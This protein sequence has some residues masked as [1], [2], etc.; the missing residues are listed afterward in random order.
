MIQLQSEHLRLWVS[1]ADGAAITSMDWRGR[2]GWQPV[3][4]PD[5]AGTGALA[6]GLYWMLPF[7]NR[8][9]DNRLHSYI[10][11]PNNA[12]P[13]ALHGTGWERAWTVR[14][15]TATTL[16]L[17]V[18]VPADSYPFG[19][20]A[21]IDLQLSTFE[22]QA[23]LSM[24]NSGAGPIPAGLGAHPYFPKYP[25]TRLQFRARHFWLE[26]PGHL[27][28][29]AVSLPPDRDFSDSAALPASWCNN[30][31]SGW[32]HI[33]SIDQ[34]DLGYNLTLRA[35]TT[36]PELMLYSDPAL[37]RF[38]VEPQSHTSGATGQA[39]AEPAIGLA[40]LAPGATLS[41]DFVLTVVPPPDDCR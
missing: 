28:T 12:D 33:F 8:A 9:R 25:G 16:S 6:A 4:V 30:N 5:R 3:L 31:F 11:Q 36:L 37:P 40:E 35:N 19:F 21:D 22:L 2:Q 32:D 24:T 38:A 13:L 34:P 17:T 10:V 14:N 39:P 18:H 20:T 26:G 29:T 15:Q 7:A 23:K 41:A 27:P 1:P